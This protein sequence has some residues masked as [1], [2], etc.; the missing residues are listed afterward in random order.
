MDELGSPAT[1]DDTW[2]P[3]T[4]RDSQR[5]TSDVIGKNHS[6]FLVDQQRAV[7]IVELKDGNW[8]VY[9]EDFNA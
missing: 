1:G 5:R 9:I 8:T 4:L 3:R 6:W 2:K 7:N